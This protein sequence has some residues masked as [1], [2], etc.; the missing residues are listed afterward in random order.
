MR[1]G[2]PEESLRE[3]RRAVELD[4]VSVAA[5]NNIGAMYIY[6]G[7][8]QAAARAY[9]SALALAPDATSIM[10]NLALTYSFMGQH[11]EAIR[12]AERARTLDPEDH[13]TLVALGYAYA[14]G[15][16]RPE[17]EQLL[18]GITRCSM[19]GLVRG[20]SRRVPQPMRLRGDG[21]CSILDAAVPPAV[22]ATAHCPRATVVVRAKHRDRLVEPQAGGPMFAPVLRCTAALMLLA[23]AAPLA[24]QGVPVAG[25]RD[26]VRTVERVTGGGGI[27]LAVYEAGAPG[28]PAIVLIHGFSQNVLTWQRQFESA[29]VD[30]FHVVAYDLRGHGDSASPLGAGHY[31]DGDHWAEDLAAVIRSR[32]LHRPVVVGWSYGGYVISDYVRRF[33]DDALGG[34]VILASTTKNGTDQALPF[35]GD[36]MLAI[37]GDLLSPETALRLKATRALADL[38]LE[39]GSDGWL[40]AYGSAMMVGPEVRQAMFARVLENDDVLARIRVPTLVVHGADDR[41]VLK[42]AAEHTARTV[43]G[44]RLLVYDGVGHAPHYQAADHFN[45]DLA[46]F[47]RRASAPRR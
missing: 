47:V 28:R 38:N 37:F 20:S 13:F 7:Q 1:L 34:I 32:N 8:S 41:I 33:G 44:A 40:T 35:F 25:P 6:A 24:G 43:P 15:G 42:T 31:T 2:Q 10:G 19:L 30:E 4:P 11:V 39:R 9:Q 27:E 16:R 22:T 3:A 36:D 23:L 12:T 29:L 14:R 46:E 21:G 5:Y 17:A 45:R 26:S 18:R